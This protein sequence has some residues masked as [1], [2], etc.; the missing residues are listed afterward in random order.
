MCMYVCMHS[1][2]HCFGP[3][4]WERLEEAERT[5]GE[6]SRFTSEGRHVV[7]RVRRTFDSCEI[8]T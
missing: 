3:A 4:E 5:P 7:R 1:L 6:E 2:F 8:S